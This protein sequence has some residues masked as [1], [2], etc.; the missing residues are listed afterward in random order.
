MSNGYRQRVSHSQEERVHN[1]FLWSRRN[2][3]RTRTESFSSGLLM[4]YFFSDW[5]SNCQHLP[6]DC[7][8]PD[9]VSVA[10]RISSLLRVTHGADIVIAITH[11][12]RDEDVH[13]AKYCDNNVDLIL[14][15]HDHDLAVH[16]SNFRA[17]N[18]TYEG[19]IKLIKSGTDFRNYSDIKIWLSQKNGK[20]LIECVRGGMTAFSYNSWNRALLTR[21]N[22]QPIA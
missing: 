2:V 18:D 8:I 10:R 16:R 9:P 22:N 7:A 4:G 20:A 15:G 3:S 6:M 13:L 12:R 19:R 5:P 17:M 1:W 14:G 21:F 11:M